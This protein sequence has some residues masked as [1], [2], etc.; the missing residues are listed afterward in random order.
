MFAA[1]KKTFLASI[2]IF[3][4]LTTGAWQSNEIVLASSQNTNIP[5]TPL[6]PSLTWSSVGSSSRDITINVNGDT[7]SLSGKA[8]KAAEQFA[9]GIIFQD[10]LNYYSNA[11]LAK[12]G[13][14]SY[15]ASQKSDG[16]HYIFYHESGVYLSVEFL[17]CPVDTS[18]VC[19]T[20]WKSEQTNPVT[21]TPNKAS[22][23][24]SSATG[25]FGKTSPADGATNLDP[26]NTTL[27]WGTYSPTP[28]KY[29]YCVKEGSTCDDNDPNWTGTNTNTSVI[30][31]DLSYGKTYYWQVKAI[32][33]LG[34]VPKTYVYADD[35]TWWTFTTKLQTQA[36][37]VGNAGVAGAILS[38]TDGT[39]KTVTADGT[40]AYSITVPYSWSGTVTPTKP[41]YVFLPKNAS[42][43]NLTAVQTIQNFTA[44]LAF[45]IS[46]NTEI[47]GVTL[48]YTDGTPQTVISDGSG[49]YSI[50]VPQGWSGT[51]TPSKTG[52]NFSP[53]NKSYV[54]VVSNQTAQ[55]YLALVTISGNAGVAGATLSYTDGTPKTVLAD[56]SGNYSIPVPYGW[57]GIVTPSK[58]GYNFSPTNRTYL[59]L[60][61]NQT[62]QNYV[63]FV[64]IS[65]NVGVAGVTLSYTDGVV[66]TAISQSNGS[67]SFPVPYNWSGTVTPTHACFTFS[68]TVKSYGSVAANQTAQDYVPSLHLAANCADV[69]VSIG[70]TNQGRF[71]ITAHSSTRAS[72][73]G[74]NAGP[75]QIASTNAI[76]LIGA[77]RLIY[78][79]GGVETSFTETMALPNGQLDKIYWL[80]WYNNTGLDTQLRI[81]NVSGSTA[82]V[83]VYIG[84]VEMP[85]S[86]FAL[87]AN[88]AGQSTRLNFAGVNNGP[89]QLVSD[90]NIVV[91]EREIYKVSGVETSFT[92]L[93]ALPNSQVDKI[94]WLPWYNNTGLDT[95]LRIGN[96]SGVAAAV[97]VYI[98]GVEMPGSPFALS[99]TGA[100]QS[101]RLNFAGVNNGPVQL[102]SDQNIVA[103]ER[104]IYKVGGVDASFSEMMALPNNQV[105]TSYW[106]PYYNNTGL[107]TQLRIG[108]VSGVAASVHVFVGG[109]EMPG[110]PFALTGTGAGQ[111]VRLNFAGVNNGPV[112][113]VSDQDIVVAEREIYKVSGV[114][115]SFTELM[116]L[117]NSQLDTTY[118]LPWY[119]NTGLDTQLRFATP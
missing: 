74:V 34:C 67:Y 38:Y 30:L 111:S 37:I 36:T 102:V 27:S 20:V 2:L 31:T 19:V 97:H 103:A 53:V 87:T 80:P 24:S 22:G 43:S 8:Y 79:V 51:V 42:F 92:E 69:N 107:D 65:G 95:Q 40:G 9:S 59:N 33:C 116:G 88:G 21:F 4:T 56:G 86:P 5:E 61:S 52:F 76:D 104:L 108:N 84:G 28:D 17:K 7:V 32:T 75:V 66:K 85:S 57:Y 29:S 18:S 93:M 16:A 70:G 78:K 105:D 55:N 73:I 62:A 12:S 54:N 115:T 119:N 72:F 81:G 100:G 14:T 3:V 71:G 15:D 90:Q 101:T 114:D 91:A 48:S 45:T 112:R 110:S 118:W 49:N 6:Y 47:A 50:I 23:Q 1:F 113:I 39:L 60:V 41:G 99:A 117:P 11:Q 26:T 109:T 63:A 35:G 44:G 77:E 64:T 82:T 25:S 46:G 106:F 89:V 13:W 96:V 10:V 58:T 94:Y 98:G 83:H 68:P